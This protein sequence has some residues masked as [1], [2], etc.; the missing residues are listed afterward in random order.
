MS[1]Q[2]NPVHV[3]RALE[4]LRNS[5]FDTVSAMGEVIDNAIEANATNIRIK[6]Q[7][8]KIR[9][10]RFDL[11]EIAFADDGLGMDKDMLHQCLQ[12]GF[13]SRYNDREGI[14]RFG[15]GMTLGAITQST[16]IE[17]YSKPR[18]G[19]W[20]FTYLDLDEMKDQPNAI[21]PEPSS[22]P[23]PKEYSSLV[24]N[25]GT[26]V[27]WKNWDREDATI[28]EMSIWIGRTYRKFI[29]K[30]IVKDGK[31]IKNPNQIHIFLDDKEISAYDPLYAIKTDYNSE[32]GKLATPI[33]IEEEIHQFDQPLKKK[34]GAS[35]IIIQFALTPEK[36]RQLGG[37]KD[38]NS[39]DNRKRLIPKNEGVSILRNNREIFYGHIPY[40]DLSDKISGRGF[41]NPDRFWGGEISF[42]AELDHWFSVKNIKVG[43]RPLPELRR[44]LENAMS[45]TIYSYRKE[46]RKVW[47]QKEVEENIKSGGATSG[48]SKAEEALKKNNPVKGGDDS[49]DIDK[50]LKESG[51]KRGEV[52]K[53]L[54]Q[55][56]SD[57]PFTFVKS[58]DIDRRG[59]FLESTIEGEKALITF[60]MNHPFFRKFY[61][62]MRELENHSKNNDELK[63]LSDKVQT[64]CYLLLG[65]FVAA[66]KE[67]NQESTY[68]AGDFIE[69]L[70]HNWTFHLSKNLDSL[71][72]NN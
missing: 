52:I 50:I 15:V 55:K 48:T 59:D 35:E 68:S 71:K 70:M 69:K 72:D 7:K 21:I 41:I 32:V 2:V 34:H 23:I 27:I 46:I 67:F 49:K 45:P 10:D 11:T 65:T 25:N 12:L 24:E 28:D 4:S 16:R 58:E 54:K 51:E 19:D 42:S 66:Q 26:L 5:D 31:V 14:G 44:A 8:E 29:G 61:E 40:F 30:E 38:G 6:I 53:I 36:W 20:N 39:P 63:E 37:G 9:S 13:S 17:V 64:I 1:L 18:G 62:A 57:R 60:N 56:M 22:K 47:K 3:G 33:K 43:A